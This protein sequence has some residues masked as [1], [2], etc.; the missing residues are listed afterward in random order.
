MFS[1][2]T[3]MLGIGPNSSSFS[4]LQTGVQPTLGPSAKTVS[5][6]NVLAQGERTGIGW[7]VRDVCREG[8]LSRRE[9]LVE[10][11]LI[12]PPQGVAYCLTNLAGI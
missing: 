4:L 5:R 1:R 3:I 12:T 7:C 9:Q 10:H 6:P 11:L 2:A 8:R